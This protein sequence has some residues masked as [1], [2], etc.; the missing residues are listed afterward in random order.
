MALCLDVRSPAA[1]GSRLPFHDVLVQYG[2]A[3]L[4]QFGDT[5]PARQYEVLHK[6]LACRT[7]AMGGS[8][9]YCA[10]C[11]KHH[12]TYHSCN[13]RHC[14]Q[15]GQAQTEE[16]LERQ[17]QRLL[18]PVPYFLVTFTLPEPVQRWM[19]SHPK[20]GYDVLFAASANALQD[21]AQNPKRLGAS[22]G[23]LG[24]LHTWS[25]TLTYHPHVHYL[26]PGGGLSLDQ[27]TWVASRPKFLLPVKALSDHFR[28]CFKKGLAKQAPDALQRL[29]AHVWRQRWV[30]PAHQDG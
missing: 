22:L 1:A 24:V 14:P 26:V 16:W 8:L 10:H 11:A 30:V 7:E 18:L 6:L 9:Y 23:M 17:Q 3:Y 27:R 28:T 5:M 29:P 13:D 15:C 19:R 2:P 21:L 25:R 12:Y 20:V 4:K